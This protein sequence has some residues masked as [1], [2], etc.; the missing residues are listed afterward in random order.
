MDTIKFLAASDLHSDLKLIEKIKKEIEKT[1][2]DFIILTGDIS[3][4][5]NDFSQLLGI[6]KNKDIFLIPGNHETKKQIEI[7]KKHYNVHL[8]GNN[9]V[10]INEHLAI[11]GSNY[12]PI[13]EFRLNEKKI[14][15]NI[16]NN[17]NQIK[18]IKTK[19]FL[20]HMPAA[21]TKLGNAS[22][23]Y[24]YIG[25][26]DAT[27]NFLNK[28]N[29]DLTLVGHIHESSGLEEIVNKNKVV[30]IAKTFKIFEFDAKK[31]KINEIKKN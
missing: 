30:N 6:F 18:N 17:F 13:G 5:K 23:Y 15:E 4:K 16:V 29:V 9:P 10:L 1:E 31:N 21:N 3:E 20:S 28:Y 19:I 14:F 11:F 2:I 7:L 24:P 27:L 25:G 26:S 22:P 12:L 8:I